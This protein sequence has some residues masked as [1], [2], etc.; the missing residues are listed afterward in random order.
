V[1]TVVDALILQAVNW[2]LAKVANSILVFLVGERAELLSGAVSFILINIVTFWYFG[3][4]YSVKG[5]SPGKLIMELEV[6][7]SQ[8]EAHLNFA[9]AY[10]RETIGKFISGVPLGI[11]FLMAAF[12]TDHRAL[13]DLIFDSRVVKSKPSTTVR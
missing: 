5:A 8:S 2:P 13:H 10:F 1:A 12:R 9:R 4:F 3:W 7:D 11:G 6:I